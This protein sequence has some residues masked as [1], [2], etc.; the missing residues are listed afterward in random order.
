MPG[1]VLRWHLLSLG[2]WRLF[3]T[4]QRRRLGEDG[5]AGW[6]PVFEAFDEG[7]AGYAPARPA[8]ANRHARHE[9]I[10]PDEA[11]S[12]RRPRDTAPLPPRGMGPASSR[13]REGR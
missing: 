6:Q 4:Q 12:P 13:F 5:V 9:S 2:P 8:H 11:M 3:E 7:A 1:L 10:L